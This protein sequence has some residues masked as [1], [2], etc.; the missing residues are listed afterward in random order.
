MH[1]AARKSNARRWF[2]IPRAP[3]AMEALTVMECPI[4]MELIRNSCAGEFVGRAQTVIPDQG[5]T[6]WLS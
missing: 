5:A 6:A 1:L 4:Q 2:A 3:Q